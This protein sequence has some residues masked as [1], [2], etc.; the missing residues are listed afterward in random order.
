MKNIYNLNI[1]IYAKHIYKLTYSSVR[2]V[3][4]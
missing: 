3:E 2:R 1:Y 4:V